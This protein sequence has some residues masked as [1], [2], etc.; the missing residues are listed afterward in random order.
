MKSIRHQRLSGHKA[1]RLPGLDNVAGFSLI[2]V[3]VALIIL[4]VGLL[5][6]AGLQATSKR[7][8]YEAL[9]RT[10]ATM[11]ARDISERMRTN[12]DQLASY[13]GTVDTTTITPPSDC[14]YDAVSN[15]T[16]DCTPAQLATYDLYEWQQAILGA[17][18]KQTGSNTG[19]LVLPTGCITVAT[20]CTSCEVT[21]AIAW[22]GL[23]K[24]A[25]PTIDTCGSTSGNYN[26]TGT[27]NVY[28]RVIAINTFI[29]DYD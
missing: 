11:L 2:E 8:S 27:D 9:Q 3:L 17:S 15:S 20:G 18:E 21:V 28:R 6:I 12:P 13:N 1:V 7:T 29:A 22:R 14:L 5:G 19:G 26:D 23:T 16:P 25:N 24:L 10:T 4:S